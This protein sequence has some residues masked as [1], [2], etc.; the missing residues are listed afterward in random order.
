MQC[1]RWKSLKINNFKINSFG[2]LKNIVMMAGIVIGCIT[3]S[4]AFSDMPSNH[5]AYEKVNEIT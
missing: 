2:K 3:V 5:W 4:S 1:K